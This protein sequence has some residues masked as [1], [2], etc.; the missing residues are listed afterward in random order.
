[1]G[2]GI[3]V[4][5]L[6]VT[7]TGN[8]KTKN[9]HQWMNVRK[10][11]EDSRAW[12]DTQ[13]QRRSILPTS[14]STVEC[15]GL[16]DVVFRSGMSYLSHPGNAMFQ[17]ILESYF[18]EHNAASQEEKVSITWRVVN[19]VV[20]APGPPSSTNKYGGRFL[21]WDKSIGGWIQLQ[22][23]NQMRSKVAVCFKLHKKQ[24]R[25]HTNR[26]NTESATYKFERQDGHKR[27][28]AQDG[29]DLI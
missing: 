21:V 28:R 12:D 16:L 6:P 8:V 27:K 24:L 18:D 3:P 19:D 17:G 1:M 10:T 23:R 2:Y 22:D 29:K 20:G 7:E 11:I 26:Q 15:P 5:L 14:N 25:A 9:L 13:Q 4:E